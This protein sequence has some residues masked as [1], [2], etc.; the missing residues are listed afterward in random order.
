MYYIQGYEVFDIYNGFHIFY[1]VYNKLFYMKNI[2]KM[3][4]VLSKESTNMW[5]LHEIFLTPL[6]SIQWIAY[7]PKYPVLILPWTILVIYSCS[8]GVTC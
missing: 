6:K 5:L 3:L 4:M 1:F 2:R 7:F 8:K